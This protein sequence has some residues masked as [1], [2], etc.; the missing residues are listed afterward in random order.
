[1]NEATTAVDGTAMAGTA[2][3]AATGK[4]GAP[5]P[6]FGTML[7]DV[8]G[9]DSL[10]GKIVN[11][12]FAMGAIRL[13]LA[14]ILGLLILGIVVSIIK[15]LTA[16]RGDSRLG[17]LIVKATQYAGF[18][19]ITLNAFKMAHIDLSA[20]LGA[21]GIAGVALGFAA[22]TSVSNFISGLFLMSE[23]TFS[24]GDVITVG[25]ITGV[26]Y[27][28]DAL[29]LKIRKFDNLLV[30]IPN[31]TLIKSNVIN[32]TRFPARRLNITI[33]VTYDTDL[34]LARRILMEAAM[35]NPA[36]LR[37][38]EPFFAV[39]KFADSG[40]ELFLGVWFPIDSYEPANNGMFVE[41]KKRFE[42]EGIRF[43]YPTM[44]VLQSGQA[45]TA[46]QVQPAPAV[47][48][49]AVST[50]GVQSKKS[51]ASAARKPAAPA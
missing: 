18:T 14:V 2:T 38:P 24:I 34:Q 35:A 26:V 30:R 8:F 45:V 27:S 46:Q 9:K 36:I 7:D 48:P 49:A 43:A 20:L 51:R 15:R 6:V 37:N 12:D 19:L 42:A 50:E 23:K 47:Q 13:V 33:L 1:M 39:Q 29:S 44:T 22:Q 28:I 16:R 21:A 3:E 31:E 10:F 32:I 25:D 11:I 4:A 17:P 5:S 41:I 40:I